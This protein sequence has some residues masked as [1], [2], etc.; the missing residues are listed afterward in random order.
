MK[1]QKPK[2]QPSRGPKRPGTRKP[3]PA[4]GPKKN[5]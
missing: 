3:K 5:Y 2:P 1:T 4:Q